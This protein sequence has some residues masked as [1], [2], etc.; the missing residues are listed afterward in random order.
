MEFNAHTCVRV[1]AVSLPPLEIN[2]IQV[3]SWLGSLVN[4]RV[5]QSQRTWIQVHK[6]SLTYQSFLSLDL[7]SV[8][9]VH[10]DLPFIITKMKHVKT[11]QTVRQ[12]S[13]NYHNAN[14]KVVSFLEDTQAI[15]MHTGEMSEARR[16]RKGQC[17]N[18]SIVIPRL[19]FPPKE[20]MGSRVRSNEGWK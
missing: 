4:E 15:R 6:Y 10:Q 16:G 13:N 20:N 12:Y 3:S 1:T 2:G 14:V 5:I 7:F 19:L 8:Q 11:L 9:K 17:K 18:H